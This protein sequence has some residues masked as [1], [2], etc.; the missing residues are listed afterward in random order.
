MEHQPTTDIQ[1]NGPTTSIQ[2]MQDEIK[3]LQA[4]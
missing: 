2:S 3:A 4:E 1:S